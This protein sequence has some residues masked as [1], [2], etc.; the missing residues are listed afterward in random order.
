MAPGSRVIGRRVEEIGLRAETGCVVL[1]LQRRSRMIR[2]RISEIRLEAGDVLLILGSRDNVRK[3]RH[4]RDLLLLEWSATELPDVKYANRARFIFLATVIAAASGIVP[5]VI[6][7]MAGAAAMI[8]AGCLNIRQAARAINR[9][10][11]MLIGAALAMAAALEATNGAMYIAHSMVAALSG[12]SAGVILSAL[13]LLIAVMTNFLSNNATALLFTPIAL[14]TALE[15]GVDPAA[16]IHAVIFAAN[17]SFA[18]P[19]AY[20]TNLLVMGPGH[21]RFSDFVRTGTPLIFIIWLAYSLF[22]P[23][24]YGL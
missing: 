5:I 11:Y 20:Q 22:A 13:F 8:P 6:A 19:M 2:S 16:F 4:S 12:A 23:W 24:Y 10:I 3:L 1:G 21:Y 14:S 17:C 18:T 9:S 7:A 15:L